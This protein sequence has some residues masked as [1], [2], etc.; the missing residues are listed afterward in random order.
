MMSQ[1]PA[2]W[3]AHL[4]SS[5]SRSRS[6]M[7]WRMAAPGL[8]PPDAENE[9]RVMGDWKLP[10]AAEAEEEDDGAAGTLV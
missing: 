3:Y 7:A 1:M 4:V 10:P 8:S 2:A 5:M 9:A 6:S